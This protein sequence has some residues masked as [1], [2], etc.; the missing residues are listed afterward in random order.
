V[1]TQAIVLYIL[2]LSVARIIWKRQENLY[3]YCLNHRQI[4]KVFWLYWQ[5]LSQ[6]V[7]LWLRKDFK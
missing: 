3:P 5:N 1:F 6:E 4:F 2:L 7:H